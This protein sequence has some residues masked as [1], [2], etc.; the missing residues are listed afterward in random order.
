M[1]K[2]DEIQST[3]KLLDLIR[4]Q[5]QLDPPSS[6]KQETATVP[7]RS[8]GK[9]GAAVRLGK[10]TVV[11]VDIGHSYIKLAKIRHNSDKTYQLLDYLD[12]P[13]NKSANLKDPAILALLK[14]TLNQFCGDESNMAVWAAITSANV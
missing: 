13:L 2:H 10:K 12:V 9:L 3:E 4:N 8:G 5:D 1:A 11:G 14:T 6:G 7:K